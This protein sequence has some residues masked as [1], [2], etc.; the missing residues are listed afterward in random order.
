MQQNEPIC[1]TSAPDPRR[2]G[3]TPDPGEFV[4][5]GQQGLLRRFLTTVRH[6]V[7]LLVGGSAARLRGLP[8]RRRRQPRFLLLRAFTAVAG[9]PV[10]R[11]LY[12]QPFPLQ[13]RRRLELL[14]P[15]YIKLGQILA[16]REDLLPQPV[17]D[18]LKELLDQLPAVPHRQFLELVSRH[19]DR[20]VETTFAH[21]DPAPLGSA[22]IG[23]IQRATLL[24]GT[25]V[26]LKVVKPGIR[27][28]LKRDTLLLKMLG[29]LLQLFLP[30]YQPRRII[31]EFCEYT[32]RETDLTRE[33]D[34]AETFAAGFRKQPGIVFPKIY[35]EYS[36]DNV[37]C[38][39]FLDGLKPT[40]PRAKELGTE[41]R[42]KL[43]DLGAEAIICMLYRDGFFHADLHPGNLIILPGP[44]CGFIDLG[45]VG[46]FDSDLKHSLLY[47]YHSLVS[48]DAENAAS[49]LCAIAESGPRSDLR[50]FRRDVEELCRQWSH[51][52][53]FGEFSLAQLI[54]LS[55]AR[56]ARHRIYFPIELV[57]MAKAIVTFEAVGNMLLPGFDVARVSRKHAGRVLLQRF[58]PLRLAQESLTALPELADALAKTP[59]L[60]TE[61]LRL[62]ERATQPPAENPLSGLRSTVFGGSCLVAGAVLA[63]FGGPWPIWAGLFV[64][65]TFLALRRGR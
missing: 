10:R 60:L 12:L 17:T 30:R 24:D 16:M 8:A 34:N 20:P 25:Q 44:R 53:R 62:I 56:G 14:G 61:G 57:L 54:M 40:D 43:I 5:L 39:E 22:S 37:L 64:V 42:E 55:V 26:V 58:G 11:D 48:G 63:G 41:D 7:A 23:Q 50:G 47:Y 35:R 33:A 4:D 28:T 29:G 46:R 36:S 15:T 49:Y 3:D 19:L 9:L 31:A 45:M 1:G 21:V 65:G 13:L 38:M 32:Q 52:T 18:E 2:P 51:R 27:E 6:S 59:R